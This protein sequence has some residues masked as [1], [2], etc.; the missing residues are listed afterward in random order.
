MDYCELI[1]LGKKMEEVF[2]MIISKFEMDFYLG[3]VHEVHEVHI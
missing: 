1:Y 3:K 2:L